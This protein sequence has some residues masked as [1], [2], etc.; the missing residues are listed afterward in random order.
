MSA[1]RLESTATGEFCLC[2]DFTRDNLTQVEDSQAQFWQQDRLKLNLA[3][4]SRADMAGLAWLIDLVSQA[5]HK[6][7]SLQLE[8]VPE[9]LLKLAKISDVQELLPLQ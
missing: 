3:E 5:R 7:V 6:S 2:G 9:T 8:N 4:V 1:L